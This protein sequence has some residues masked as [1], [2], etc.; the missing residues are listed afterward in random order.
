M[1][2]PQ[3]AIDAL[4]S[5]SLAARRQPA[6]PAQGTRVPTPEKLRAATAHTRSRCPTQ[7]ARLSNPQVAPLTNDQP[8][9]QRVSPHQAPPASASDDLNAEDH[10]ESHELLRPCR[11]PDCRTLLAAN[12]MDV[13]SEA[14][15]TANAD[16]AIEYPVLHDWKVLSSG[17]YRGR[18]FGNACVKGNVTTSRARLVGGYIHT[19]T[20]STYRLGRQ[21]PLSE[22]ERC[23]GVCP[24]CVDRD[25]AYQ[26]FLDGLHEA[27]QA[28]LAGFPNGFILH[29][30]GEVEVPI[31]MDDDPPWLVGIDPFI[32]MDATWRGT[33]V[34]EQLYHERASPA[35]ARSAVNALPPAEPHAHSASADASV[36]SEDEGDA[37]HSPSLCHVCDKEEPGL[38]LCMCMHMPAR[39][40]AW[41]CSKSD[42][43]DEP[44][45]GGMRCT[46]S[47]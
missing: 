12:E 16:S 17:Q 1:T 26:A 42:V 32:R 44:C 2:L 18:V 40:E 41:Q 29:A 15:H 28:Y 36:S 43:A 35:S 23:L 7:E 3:A 27:H 20:G 9:R 8:K 6:S 14:P 37:Q 10:L 45:N 25:G 4:A 47:A 31:D 21:R 34:L 13:D 38:K 22:I 39:C 11:P 5:T 30:D 33:D 19:E 46:C 24:A